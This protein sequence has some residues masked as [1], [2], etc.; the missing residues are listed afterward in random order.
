VWHDSFIC[1]TWLIHMCDMTHSYVWH[2]SFICVTCVTWL[3][4]VCKTRLIQMWCVCACVRV[5]AGVCMCVCMC[6]CA[7]AH[8]FMCMCVC[9]YEYVYVRVCMYTWIL[10]MWDM[11]LC[12]MCCYVLVGSLGGACGCVWVYMNMCMYMYVCIHESFICGTW[13]IR[14]CDTTL[15]CERKKERNMWCCVFL[16]YVTHSYVRHNSGIWKKERKKERKKYAV[17][18]V[19]W[20]SERCVWHDFFLICDVTHSYVRR[21]YF[22]CSAAC[23]L[24]FLEMGGCVCVCVC[25]RVCIFM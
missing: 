7:C 25:V 4:H 16:S 9:I 8:G 2:D 22:I 18:R 1:V 3:I 17:I 11:T 14:T 20:L 23:W 15:S 6:M 19:G 13:L 21:D 12:H 5:C 10:H 24:A